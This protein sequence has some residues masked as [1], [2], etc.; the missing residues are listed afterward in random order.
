MNESIENEMGYAKIEG[1]NIHKI[2]ELVH[3]FDLYEV[4]GLF[5]LI[6]LLCLALGNNFLKVTH[7]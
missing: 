7:L 1:P 4:M 2:D 3:F 6:L 5:Y